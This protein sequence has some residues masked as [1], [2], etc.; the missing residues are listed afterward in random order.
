MEKKI[1]DF[2]MKIGGAR[3]DKKE[4]SKENPLPKM[5]NPGNFLLISRDN[6]W[7][8]TNGEEL[9]ASGVPQGI[10]YW[11]EQI[12][13]AI[14]PHPSKADERSM[15]NYFNIVS[16][17]KEQ[18]NQVNEPED[19]ESFYHF[20]HQHYLTD[21][22]AYHIFVTD[23]A[24]DVV[25]QKLLQE[26]Q[27][28]Y[29]TYEHRAR[30]I[31]FGIPQ[32]DKAA[33]RKQQ[34]EIAQNNK[35][36][37]N[38]P[39]VNRKKPFPIPKL[40][41]FMRNGPA[42]LPAGS[43]AGKE[44]F[45]ALGIRGVE[46]GLWMS[47][48]DAQAALDQCYHALRDLAY[49]LDIAPEDISFGG[50]LALSFGAR[51]HGEVL[52]D[53]QTKQQLICLPNGNGNGFLA[54]AW[55]YVL[56]EYISQGFGQS[57]SQ[58]VEDEL[59]HYDMNVT[60]VW[61]KEFLTCFM[62]QTITIT[63]NEQNAM[64]E[65]KRQYYIQKNEQILAKSIDSITPKQLTE[66]QQIQ[67]DSVVQEV[68]DNRCLAKMGMYSGINNVNPSI[69]KLST[70]YKGITGRSILKRKRSSI[71]YNLVMLSASERPFNPATQ[72]M[73]KKEA[74][75]FSD[76]SLKM[77]RYYAKT[78]HGDHYE[79]C[80]RFARAFDCY[81]ADKLKKAGIQNQ[82]LTAHSEAFV[83]QDKNGETIYAMPMG[84]EREQINQKFDALILTLKEIGLFHPRELPEQN[85]KINT[86]YLTQYSSKTSIAAIRNLVAEQQKKTSFGQNAR[87]NS[88]YGR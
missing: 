55:A 12:R 3:K 2:G 71:N 43:H 11:R 49:V 86:E 88:S 60:P 56:D 29:C 83:F 66:E 33:L 28:E 1:N 61:V 62:W 23:P 31:F 84:K 69:E 48:A 10:A 38:S 57:L 15:I 65:Q 78:A 35:P 76:G 8:E 81:I 7:P 64:M 82:Y 17:L 50:K 85:L 44:E 54:H 30:K 36:N 27:T 5:N 87:T 37:P 21:S 26:A 77:R 59:W 72:T 13:K 14:P 70:V 51:G 79:F 47:D 34:K 46:F 73:Q 40:S 67:W 24:K 18:V 6:I 45:L 63:A 32:K 20:I 16:E 74:N 42:Y 80:E 39:Y 68:Y 52:A 75:H 22:D 25:S 4:E 41:T 19:V 9:V 53:Y 58:M